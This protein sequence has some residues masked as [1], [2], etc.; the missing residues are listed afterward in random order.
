EPRRVAADIEVRALLQPGMDVARL[1][2]EAVLDVELLR[3][4]A[5]EGD[6]HPCQRAVGQ[7]LLPFGLV[8]EVAAEMALTEEQPRPAAAARLALLQEGA[9][10]G[11][12][13]AGA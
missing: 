4:V 13:G 10:G 7:P 1:L 12:A 5:R 9:I 6:V 8:E 3:A 2:A 11:N